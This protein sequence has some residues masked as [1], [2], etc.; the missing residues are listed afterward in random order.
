MPSKIRLIGLDL[1]GTLLNREKEITPRTRRALLAAQA[2][3]VLLVPITGRPEGGIPPAVRELLGLRY[4]VTSNG[5]TIRD[6]W[7][8][9][10]LLEHHLSPRVCLEVLERVA[11]FEMIREAFR[12]GVG[13]MEQRDYDVLCARYT[14]SAMLPYF[15]S[16]RQAL[17][18]TLD[19]FLRE[20]T[21][22]VEELLFLTGSPQ[23]KQEVQRALSGL[24]EI[25]FADPFPNDLEVIAGGI[26]KGEALRYLAK[27][28]ELRP[29]ETMAIGD[30]S[31]DLPLL[32]AAGLG[33]AM[34][35]AADV[36]KGAADFVTATCEEDGVG[37][38]I[39]KYVL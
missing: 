19:R 6:L 24:P 31:S 8:Q 14:G 12:E 26:D 33:V 34:G 11:Q 7:E 27:Q 35:N 16:T 5:A 3:G 4:T 32:Q 28:L 10:T 13:Y 36:L 38:A 39:E 23:A 18:R 25:G 15:Q 30:G 9:R 29:E 1:D 2:A 21:R 20:D 17:S 22:S 37:L